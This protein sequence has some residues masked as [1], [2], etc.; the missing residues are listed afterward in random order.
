[1]TVHFPIAF[2]CAATVFLLLYLIT[3]IQS[4]DNTVFHCLGAGVLFS[5]VAI[6]TG[7]Y[8]W[9]LN[10]MARPVR[11]VQIKKKLSVLLAVAAAIAFLLRAA[12]PDIL[13]EIDAAGIIYAILVLSLFPLVTVIGWFGAALTFPTEKAK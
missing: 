5:L 6:A 1:M 9:W 13:V 12:R 4:F 7:W 2:M 10:Y 3:G 8:T 11:P